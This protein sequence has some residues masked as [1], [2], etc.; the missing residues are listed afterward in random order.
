MNLSNG[1]IEVYMPQHPNARSNGTVLEHRLVAEMKLGRYLKPEETVHHKD[2]NRTNNHPDNLIVFRT[3]ADHSRFHKI[4]VLKDMGDG[5]YVCPVK[6][7]E[8]KKCKFCGKYYIYDKAHKHNKFCSWEC[9]V[10]NKDNIF[11]EKVMNNKIPNKEELEVLIHS[12]NFIKI[13]EMYGV[14]DNAVRKWCRKYNL[15]YKYRDLH[16][17]K[18]KATPAR[19]FYDDTHKVNMFN[20]NIN[21]TFNSLDE[22]AKYL[23]ENHIT[24]EDAAFKGIRDNISNAHRKQSKYCGCYW[25]IL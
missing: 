8:I 19:L 15:P 6:E 13:G 14:S 20:E 3:N 2:E 17:K 22:A 7:A 16:P 5:T 4:G 9:Y 1:Y 25:S 11:E 10:E 24:K 23:I 18:E 21:I 12:V